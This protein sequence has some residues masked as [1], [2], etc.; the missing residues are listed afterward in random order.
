MT[1]AVVE[2]NT[3][4]N[5]QTLVSLENSEEKNLLLGGMEVSAS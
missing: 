2:L 5:R 3:H 1:E 4:R